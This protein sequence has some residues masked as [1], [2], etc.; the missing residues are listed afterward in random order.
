MS[1]YDEMQGVATELMTEFQQGAVVYSHP[2]ADTGDEWNP[3]PGTPTSYTLKATV[4]GV[5]AKYIEDGY[6]SA[7][8]L[9][10]TAAVFDVDPVQAGTVTIDGRE[11]QIIRVDALPGAGVTVAWKMFCKS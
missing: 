3:T 6:I 1:F 4:R 7:S 5:Q 2:G 9:E 10:V 8:D 11:H